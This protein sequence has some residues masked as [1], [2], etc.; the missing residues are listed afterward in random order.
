MMPDLCFN[1]APNTYWQW[2]RRGRWGEALPPSLVDILKVTD[3]I[4]NI[5]LLE[6]IEQCIPYVV[7]LMENYESSHHSRGDF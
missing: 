3:Y 6:N 5:Y 7:I 2:C 4:C 1:F